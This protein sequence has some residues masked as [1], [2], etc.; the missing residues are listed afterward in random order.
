MPL[1]EKFNV[2]HCSPKNKRH[3]SPINRRR[4]TSFGQEAGARVREEPWPEGFFGVSTAQARQGRVNSL[5]L[6]S[7]NHLAYTSGLWLPGTRP[8]DE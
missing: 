1:K 2:I 5:G 3:G 7:L 4:N 8:W 6:A